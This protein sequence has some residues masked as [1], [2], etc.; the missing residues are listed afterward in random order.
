MKVKSGLTLHSID[1]WQV[2]APSFDMPACGL[3][4]VRLNTS[5]AYLWKKV[6]NDEFDDLQLADLLVQGY[7][8]CR[9][10]ALD[11]AH[12]LLGQWIEVGLVEL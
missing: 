8:I 5:A 6:A 12:E 10:V 7:A 3:P 11:D 4:L 1:D 2:V 9:S